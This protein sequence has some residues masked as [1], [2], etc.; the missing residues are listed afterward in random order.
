M[1]LVEENSA[2][3]AVYNIDHPGMRLG[4]TNVRDSSVTFP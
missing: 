4:W 2:S 3:S 1:V